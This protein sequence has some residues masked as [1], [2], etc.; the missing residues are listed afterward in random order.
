MDSG[1]I[2]QKE[3]LRNVQQKLQAKTDIRVNE[4]LKA[5]VRSSYMSAGNASPEE[6][7]SR[8]KGPLTQR[9]SRCCNDK[10]G[11]ITEMKSGDF[12]YTA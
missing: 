2:I 3:V 9:E 10:M 11:K 6:V 12:K 7:C 5:C 8:T 4:M 1:N